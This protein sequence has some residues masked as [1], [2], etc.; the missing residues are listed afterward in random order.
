[1][2]KTSIILLLFIV[3]Q[4]L[5]SCADN[6]H[7]PVAFY[8]WK[9]TFQLNKSQKELLTK[10]QTNRLYVKFFDVVLNENNQVAPVSKI[11]F[12]QA[13]ST[14]IIPCVFIQNAVFVGDRDAGALAKKMTDLIDRIAQRNDLK[15]N[16]IQIDC[17]WTQGSRE[18]YFRFLQSLQKQAPDLTISCTVRL[19]QVKYQTKS[20][21]PPV[22]K[23]LLMCYNMDDID[24]FSTE[25]SI[26]SEKVLKEYLNEESSYPLQLDL[27]LPVYQWGL[28]FRLGKLSLIANDINKTDL[29]KH[30]VQRI[31]GNI[32]RATRNCFVKGTYLCKGD[33]VRL[34]E[35]TPAELIKIS[36]ALSKTKLSFHQ[37]IFYHLSQDNINQYDAQFF[38]EINTL[39]P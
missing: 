29:K 25:N 11:D 5:F 12:K 9:Q 28:M 22:K 19:H 37:V 33:L 32:Y 15:F 27:A 7:P 4:L 26:V 30:H 20:G 39:I 3:N 2:R 10:C 38:S 14:E 16:E 34:E 1:M 8:Y 6:E 35:S 23:G 24:E 17:D 31:E 36:K 13:P 18:N 21:V